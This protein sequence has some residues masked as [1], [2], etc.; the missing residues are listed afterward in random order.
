MPDEARF[1][2]TAVEIRAVAAEMRDILSALDVRSANE[3]ATFPTPPGMMEALAASQKE[4]HGLE[5]T[6]LA[7]EETLQISIEAVKGK[8]SYRPA[9]M[10]SLINAE[11]EQQH[12][13]SHEPVAAENSQ[14]SSINRL[15]SAL[16]SAAQLDLD[17]CAP[18]ELIDCASEFIE[19][20]FHL[21]RPGCLARW[22]VSPVADS[23]SEA[24][25]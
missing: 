7:L 25:T 2:L 15:Q 13:S 24:S 4:I 16:A 1:Q 5:K 23:P 22:E 11:R 8:V 18:G 21:T 6:L 17:S 10:T 14:N 12:R 9:F 20:L 19:R 3:E